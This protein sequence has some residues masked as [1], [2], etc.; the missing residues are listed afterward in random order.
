[1]LP[2]MTRMTSEALGRFLA[3]KQVHAWYRSAMACGDSSGTLHGCYPLVVISPLCS[4]DALV[5]YRCDVAEAK[6]MKASG[7]GSCLGH[8]T[9]WR[10][11]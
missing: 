4:D 10:V 8:K 11:P 7:L 3:S 5:H 6:A 2:S 1:M 9:G